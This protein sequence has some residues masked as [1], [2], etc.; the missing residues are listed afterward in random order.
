MEESHLFLDSCLLPRAIPSVNGVALDTVCLPWLTTGTVFV[1]APFLS[2]SSVS[3]HLLFS[4]PLPP[5]EPQA[6]FLFLALSCI[7]V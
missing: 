1:S 2:C 6:F 3:T 7:V 5:F 4:F